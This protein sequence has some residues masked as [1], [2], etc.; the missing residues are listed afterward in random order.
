MTVG[1]GTAAPP[2]HVIWTLGYGLACAGLAVWV[3]GSRQFA[4]GS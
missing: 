2:E 3:I 1:N 4:K